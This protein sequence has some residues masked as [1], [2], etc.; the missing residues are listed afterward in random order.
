MERTNIKARSENKAVIWDMDGVIADTGDHHF[1]SW[2]EVFAKRGVDFTEEKFR[3]NFGQRNDNIIKKN[4]GEQTSQKE[5]EIIASEKEESFRRRA[6]QKLRPLP[7]VIELLASLKEN[8]FKV[9]LAS[10]GPIDNIRL[11]TSSLGID[12]YFQA[13]VSGR[14][15]AEGKPSPQSFLL[16]AQKLGVEPRHCIVVEDAVAGVIAAKRAGMHCLA[17]TNTHPKESLA[18][19]DLVVDTL[20]AV[21]AS[22][23]EELISS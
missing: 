12:S 4:L 6:R 23:L 19:A 22:D 8:G 20:E 2:Q 17:V 14:D 13:I 3:Q 1:E 18:E 15:V 11:L 9:A 5:I 21:S 7:G 16:A 10:S